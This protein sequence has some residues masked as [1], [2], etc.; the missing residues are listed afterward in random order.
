MEGSQEQ[1]GGTKVQVHGST[2]PVQQLAVLSG[3]GGSLFQVLKTEGFLR[4]A[5]LVLNCT[6]LVVRG[7][8]KEVLVETFL[9]FFFFVIRSW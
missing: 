1:C 3:F 6:V 9:A 4:I 2:C 7:E 8:K 5:V